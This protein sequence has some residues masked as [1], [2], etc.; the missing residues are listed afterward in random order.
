MYT[1]KS[2][3]VER[4]CRSWCTDM[5]TDWGEREILAT[6]SPLTDEENQQPPPVIQE[7]LV[8]T[9]RLNL[10]SQLNIVHNSR[11]YICLSVLLPFYYSPQQATPLLL[12]PPFPPFPPPPALAH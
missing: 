11:M 10:R 4:G 1:T 8:R 3:Q 9:G 7:F 6:A 2:V 12:F 5:H